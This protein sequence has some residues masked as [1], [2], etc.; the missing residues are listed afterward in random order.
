VRYRYALAATLIACTVQSAWGQI[1]RGAVRD[2]ASG[3][4]IPGAVLML[5][6]GNDVVLGRNITN[7]RGEYGIALSSAMQRMR[8]VRIGFRPRTIDI[9]AATSRLDIR[10]ASIPTMLE[11]VQVS[12]NSQCPRR[13]DGPRAFG[14]WQQARDGL[15]ATVVARS[16][17]PTAMKRLQFARDIEG[18]GSHILRQEVAVDTAGMLSAPFWAA[19]SA[20]DFVKSGFSK[21]SAGRRTL[22]GP[23]ADIL[24][25]EH[26][27]LGY[28]FRLGDRNAAR[29]NQVGLEF[30]AAKHQRGVAEIAG[31]LWIDTVARV[32]KDIEYRYVGLGSAIDALRPGGSIDFR[33]ISNGLVLIDR[34]NIRSISA[35]A[36]T[37]YDAHNQPRI[38]QWFDAHETGGE[39]ARATWPDSA[40]WSASLGTLRIQAMT[41][42]NRP[43][44]GATV[45]LEHTGYFATADSQ[46]RIEIR[47]L[48]PGPYSAVVFDPLLGTVDLTIP[49]PITFVAARDTVSTFTLD[50]PTIED[51]VGKACIA[52]GTPIAHPL[53][54]T[55]WVLGRVM[56]PQ[57]TQFNG[58][59]WRIRVDRGSGD[60]LD[61]AEGRLTPKGFFEFCQLERDARVEISVWGDKNPP[62]VTVQT[63][64]EKVTILPIPIT[65]K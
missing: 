20:D 26:F 47:D 24:V 13:A 44:A 64:R 54:G 43:A 5:L 46:G 16:V 55:A 35:S 25:D 32:I 6:G 41:R 27:A 59:R 9:P 21:D 39:L 30:A 61:V 10:M 1:L 57:G 8:V 28:C 63:L 14:L 33:E 42:D 31:T 50:V 3:Q 29:P 4:A 48:L 40:R 7:E 19:R 65:E 18:T 34:W 58:W 12:D 37:T 56:A 15:L 60:W 22:F 49:T 38:R 36:D 11:P 45:L 53:S 51:F 23:D 52:S 2:S 17:Q 62:R